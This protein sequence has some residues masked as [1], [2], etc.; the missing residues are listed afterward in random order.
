MRLVL[1]CHSHISSI[2]KVYSTSFCYL[3]CFE[4]SYDNSHAILCFTALFIW[5]KTILYYTLQKYSKTL[6]E[7]TSQITT[8]RHKRKIDKMCLISIIIWFLSLTKMITTNAKFVTVLWYFKITI[9]Y[10]AKYLTSTKDEIFS[11]FLSSTQWT[12]INIGALYLN[13]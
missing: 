12:K 8:A 10:T 3:T 1:T 9:F 2:S 6:H 11:M 7:T 5:T 13:M 4:W